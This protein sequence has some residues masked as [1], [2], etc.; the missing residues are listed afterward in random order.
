MFFT[1]G[2]TGNPKMAAHKHTYALGHLVTAKYWHCCERD[3]LHLTISD[4]GWGKSLW[5]KLYGQWLCEGAVFVYDFD[6]FDASDILP[7]FAKYNITTFCAPPTMLRML[8]KEDLSKYDLSSIHHMTT[9]GEALN[10]EVF[11]QFK[12]ATGLEISEGFGQ[13]ETTLT[14]ANLRGTPLKLG[15]M[16]KAS[17]QYDVDLVDQ[18]G[19]TVAPGETGEI[20]IRTSRAVPCGLYKEYYLDS[21]K[22]EEAWHDGFITPATP[23]GATRTATSGMSGARTTL[24]SPPATASGR[25]R[26]RASSWS[27]PMLWSAAFPRPGR[28]QRSGS[29]GEHSAHQG[30]ERLRSLKKKFRIT[31]NPIQRLTNIPA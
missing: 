19:N 17:P 27:C 25:L 2:T 31:S 21:E 11:R 7:M 23:H 3:G 22:T 10:P 20:V 28:G 18:D 8:I 6:R 9:A 15:S 14:I 12:A 16:G 1:S 26:S 13:T 24:S 5:G 30:T 4:T 29:Q